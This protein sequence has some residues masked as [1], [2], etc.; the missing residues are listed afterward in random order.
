MTKTFRE[1]N[2]FSEVVKQ[3]I[4][5]NPELI[6]TKL[7]YAIKRFE[8]TNLTTIFRDFNR[9]LGDVRI[10][11]ALT[12]KVTGAIIRD[13]TAGVRGFAYDKAG[14]KAVIKAETAIENEWLDKEF[15]VKPFICTADLGQFN[16]TEEEVEVFTG[17]VCP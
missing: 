6:D 11:H 14:L 3:L 15:E 7:G 12:D 5:R 13:N 9:A 2:K 1:L 16:L 10:D 17:L 8:E 4:T